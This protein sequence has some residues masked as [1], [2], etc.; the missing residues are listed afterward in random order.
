MEYLLFRATAI[1]SLHERLLQRFDE[2]DESERALATV[3]TA[4]CRFRH[5]VVKNT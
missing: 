2:V 4:L 1:K 5:T 3:A